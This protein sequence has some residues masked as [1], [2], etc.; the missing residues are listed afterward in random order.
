MDE[1]DH[2][3]MTWSDWFRLNGVRRTPPRATVRFNHYPLVMSE[4]LAGTG[5]AL[6]WRPL[7]DEMLEAGIL[8][9]VGAATVRSDWGWW[10]V[11]SERAGDQ[12]VART[13]DWIRQ[14]F[15]DARPGT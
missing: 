12:D 10:L 1:G 7:V 3:W 13:L 9:A 8:V 4:V 11:W 2:P 6:G 15:P 14:W 5:I